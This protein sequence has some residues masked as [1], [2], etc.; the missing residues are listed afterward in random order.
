MSTKQS[1][2]YGDGFHLYADVLDTIGEGAT[3]D[4]PVY[5]ELSEFPY[6]EVSA[7]EEHRWVKLCIPSKIA[8]ALGLIP[9]DR[10]TPTSREP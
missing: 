9:D 5:L 3:D 1:I 4:P 8:V 6:F 2:K 10:P 7:T